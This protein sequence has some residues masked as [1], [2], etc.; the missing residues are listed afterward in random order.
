LIAAPRKATCRRMVILRPSWPRKLTG[1]VMLFLGVLGLILPF[2]QGFL[3]LAAGTFVL[4]DQHVWA[5]R[6]WAK[7]IARWP[8]LAERAEGMEAGALARTRRLLGRA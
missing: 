8:S 1:Y 6:L 7:I 3:F 5:A 4:R 2:L